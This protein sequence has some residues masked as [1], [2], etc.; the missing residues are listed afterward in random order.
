MEYK[1]YCK[2]NVNRRY[3]DVKGIKISGL[4][5]VSHPI[6]AAKNHWIVL[7]AI[8]A[9]VIGFMLLRF[10]YKLF[11]LVL[12]FMALFFVLFI[13]GNRYEII[14]RVGSGGMAT[15]YKARDTILNR[16]VA[17]ASRRTV[18][19]RKT[20]FLSQ[21]LPGSH[22]ERNRFIH[23]TVKNDFFLCDNF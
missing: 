19:F 8:F 14:E 13:I 9:V 2:E 7:L 1:E 6:T 16:Y 20:E 3:C 23:I 18:C 22:I 21:L 17:V 5:L 11:L 12:G 10:D 4:N 15:V